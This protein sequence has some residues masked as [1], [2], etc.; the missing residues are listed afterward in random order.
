MRFLIAFAFFASLFAASIDD[1]G[2]LGSG[3]RSAILGSGGR[4]ET[5]TTTESRGPA[6]GSGASTTD[7]PM[8]GSG[9]G[10]SPTYGSGVGD[11]SGQLGSGH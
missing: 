2:Q 8:V 9:V 1:S 10:D 7:S 5:E 11:A 6:F 4:T 3:A